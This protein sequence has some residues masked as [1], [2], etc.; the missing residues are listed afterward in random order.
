MQN[1]QLRTLAQ[2]LDDAQ[3]LPFLYYLMEQ[4]KMDKADQQ[5]SNTAPRGGLMESTFYNVDKT[6]IYRYYK[7]ISKIF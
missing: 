2:E 3:E 7:P 5:V 4:L 1:N 6:L